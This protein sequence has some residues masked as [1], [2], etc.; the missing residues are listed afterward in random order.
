MK[1][2]IVS[3]TTRRSCARARR[4]M[5]M[6]RFSFLAANPSSAVWQMDRK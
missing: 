2:A 5:S 6:S 1:R 3:G 4:S